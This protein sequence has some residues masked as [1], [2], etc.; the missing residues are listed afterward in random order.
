MHV[1]SGIPFKI[2]VSLRTCLGCAR[3]VSSVALFACS[4]PIARPMHLPVYS[5]HF[6]G[7]GGGR[8]APQPVAAGPGGGGGGGAGQGN[9]QIPWPAQRTAVVLWVPARVFEKNPLR[10][11][12]VLGCWNERGLE[13]GVFCTSR[14]TA[15]LSKGRCRIPGSDLSI[16]NRVTPLDS[17][18]WSPPP[19]RMSCMHTQNARPDPSM[20]NLGLV[21]DSCEFLPMPRGW[22]NPD[23][24][25]RPSVH[26]RHFRTTSSASVDVVLFFL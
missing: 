14:R 22:P 9:W 4:I 13:G 25:G 26:P 6:L 23:G 24:N 7:A 20:T 17:P 11:G 10:P 12:A 18:T 5:E 1:A 16:D 21:H 8:P 2:I 19:P 15:F 3:N